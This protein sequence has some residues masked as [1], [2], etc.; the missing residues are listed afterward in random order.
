VNESGQQVQ[1]I[2]IKAIEGAS[3]QRIFSSN[4]EKVSEQQAKGKE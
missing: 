4:Y 2:A 1:T 3:T